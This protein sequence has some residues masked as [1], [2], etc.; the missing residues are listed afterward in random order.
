MPKMNEK[1]VSNAFYLARKEASSHNEALSSR[2]GAADMMAINRGRLY[3]IESD[4]AIPH[5][6]EVRMMAHLYHAPELCN[7]FCRHCCPL[8]RDVPEV[9]T[10]NI[11]SIVLNV[12]RVLKDVYVTRD[13]L[14]DITEDGIIDDSEK[15]DLNRILENLDRITQVSEELKAWAKKNL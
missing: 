8:G 5:P 2:E 1:T 3:Q 11:D 15:D 12:V 13:K 6:E 4:V 9:R 7:H 14:L 10:S